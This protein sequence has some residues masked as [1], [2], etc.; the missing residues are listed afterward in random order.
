M[1]CVHLIIDSFIKEGYY[2]MKKIGSIIL[3]IFFIFFIVGFGFGL[4]ILPYDE[5]SEV[6]NRSLTQFPATQKVNIMN[7]KFTEQFDSY[8]IDQFPLRNTWIKSYLKWQMI[9]NQTFV[10]DYY[11]QNDWVYPKPFDRVNREAIHFA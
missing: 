7:G 6:E 1:I 4:F 2:I 3:S 11:I 10:N 5:V 8:V 9:S